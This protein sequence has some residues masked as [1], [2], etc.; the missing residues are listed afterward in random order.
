L[1]WAQD[2]VRRIARSG[3]VHRLHA[4]FASNRIGD[5]CVV[6]IRGNYRI[7]GD[8]SA[9]VGCR[10]T[11]SATTK[12]IATRRRQ[13]Q[14]FVVTQL[15]LTRSAC[16]R[17]VEVLYVKL[18]ITAGPIKA[19]QAAYVDLATIIAGPAISIEETIL[20]D[21]V[22]V[23]SGDSGREASFI[24]VERPCAFRIVAIGAPIAVVIDAIGALRRSRNA[25]GWR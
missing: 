18:K 8:V 16:G 6:A 22:F 4:R 9:F 14:A 23:V 19:K 5:V 11:H 24:I 13:R 21:Q 1:P 15:D 3:A 20:L 17:R 7:R 12:A 10:I 2:A 25:I